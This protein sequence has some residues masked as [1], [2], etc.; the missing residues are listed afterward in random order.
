MPPL[1]EK[2]S[3]D[4]RR[5]RRKGAVLLIVVACIVVAGLAM[6]G[7]ARQS[8]RLA[9]ASVEEEVELQQRWG[10]ISLQRT[11][12]SSAPK[13]FTDS[14]KRMLAVGNSGPFP[15]TIR[16]RVLLGGIEFD[17]VLSDEQ[18]KLNLNRVYQSRGQSV[19][20]TIAEKMKGLGGIRIRLLPEA[21]ST[22][23]GRRS[24]RRIDAGSSADVDQDELEKP[25]PPSAFRHWGQVF[26]LSNSPAGIESNQLLPAA[27]T[28]LTCWGRGEINITR[29]ADD[30]IEE[31][32]RTALGP[33]VARKL[34][35]Q[36]RKNPTL[37][38]RQI[39]MQ[40]DVDESELDELNQLLTTQSSTYSLWLH[41]TSTNG[42]QR[43]FAVA[44]PAGA[45][46]IKTERFQF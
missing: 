36:Y 42:P 39:A 11:I 30:V 21:V 43:W 5:R 12:L 29:A 13:M 33:G 8:L 27:T 16:S 19:T 26:D 31:A 10:T 38:I 46:G 23:R 37:N 9:T 40:L 14:D 4:R 1:S 44:S 32:C 41:S 24:E 7:V 35:R 15:N 2:L 25:E 20:Q 34:V 22:A 6:V 17:A 3:F 28:R 45:V 18:A